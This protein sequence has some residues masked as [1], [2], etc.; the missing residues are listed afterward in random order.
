MQQKLDINFLKTTSQ[1]FTL[2]V[3]SFILASDTVLEGLIILFLQRKLHY[4]DE[5]ITAEVSFEQRITA[6]LRV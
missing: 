6:A 2:K 5:H 1:L 4:S 3:H